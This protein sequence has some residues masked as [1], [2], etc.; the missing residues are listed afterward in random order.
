[1]NLH[2]MFWVV[3]IVV[4]CAGIAY[5]IWCWQQ[6]KLLKSLLS[7]AEKMNLTIELPP[8][9]SVQLSVA[10]EA[11]IS[12]G[13]CQPRMERVTKILTREVLRVEALLADGCTLSPR[14]R[15]KALA[16]V[17][18]REKAARRLFFRKLAR[19]LGEENP[20]LPL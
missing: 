10:I 5:D 14:E 17:C 13:R 11:V 15:N 1:M 19:V 6:R 18:M 8:M 4:V 12:H 16:R 7:M 20:V 9:P 2:P 3:A